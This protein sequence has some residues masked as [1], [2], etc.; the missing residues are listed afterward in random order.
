MRCFSRPLLLLSQES[1]SRNSGLF[2]IMVVVFCAGE[3]SNSSLSSEDVE[4]RLDDSSG[5]GMSVVAAFGLREIDRGEVVQLACDSGSQQKVS[6]FHNRQLRFS[7]RL[8]SSIACDVFE[9]SDHC[10]A[11]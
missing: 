9:N 3:D 5:T 4:S 7:N 1:D 11:C 2:D 10:G 6:R 8:P